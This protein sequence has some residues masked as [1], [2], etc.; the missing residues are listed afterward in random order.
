[1]R[2]RLWVISLSKMLGIEHLSVGNGLMEPLTKLQSSGKNLNLK[3]LHV[4][5]LL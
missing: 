5:Y 3:S 2:E 4:L 1:M